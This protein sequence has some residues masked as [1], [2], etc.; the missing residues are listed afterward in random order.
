M[1]EMR[2][3]DR[4]HGKDDESRE[5]GRGGDAD[6]VAAASSDRTGRPQPQPEEGEE[7]RQHGNAPAPQQPEMATFDVHPVLPQG[8]GSTN[9]GGGANTEEG[10]RGAEVGQDALLQVFPASDPA[11]REAGGAVDR[12]EPG[13]D[14]GTE[15]DGGDDQQRG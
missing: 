14:D 3:E 4:S 10:G 5:A 13:F 11:H 12:M 6:G 15:K 9:A 7:R 1:G 2:V 8:L